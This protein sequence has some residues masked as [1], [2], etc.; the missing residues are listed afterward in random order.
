LIEH[1]YGYRKR[2]KE[3][4][5]GGKAECGNADTYDFRALLKEQNDIFGKQKSK[6]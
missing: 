5:D 2:Q 3:Q 4:T 1:I 6:K